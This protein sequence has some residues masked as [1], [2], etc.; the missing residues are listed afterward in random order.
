MPAMHLV[1]T[2]FP[3]PLS[4]H[5]PVT[6]PAGT[7]RSTPVSACTAP[8]CLSRPRTSSSALP[9]SA[10]G[11][12]SAT[13]PASLSSV[14]DRF[15]WF[16]RGL[17]GSGAVPPRRSPMSPFLRRWDVVGGADAGSDRGAECRRG[18]ELVLDH[19]VAHVLGVDPHRGQE[20]RRL[21]GA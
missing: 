5:R 14:T 3:A 4:P 6:C 7:S 20:R 2:V 10:S 19:G 9:V 13:P 17:D 1:S 11:A 21:L 16:S 12:A 8:K 18:D 15:P